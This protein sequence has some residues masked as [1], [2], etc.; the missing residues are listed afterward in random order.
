MLCYGYLEWKKQK[1]TMV[2]SVE[3]FY[4]KQSKKKNNLLYL[5]FYHILQQYLSTF[6]F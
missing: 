1:I 6:Q 5:I 2:I 3:S 4:Y